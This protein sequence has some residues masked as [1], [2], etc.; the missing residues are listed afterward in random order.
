[1]PVFRFIHSGFPEPVFDFALT[2]ETCNLVIA[3]GINRMNDDA[4]EKTGGQ[5][6]EI[7]HRQINRFAQGMAKTHRSTMLRAVPQ[8]MV[9]SPVWVQAAAP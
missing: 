2:A 4:C 3:L 6:R 8:R 7:F 1:M 5:V 9:I